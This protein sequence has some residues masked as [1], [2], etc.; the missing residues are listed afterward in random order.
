MLVTPTK[1]RIGPNST[2]HYF[3][4]FVPRFRAAFLLTILALFAPVM[5]AQ[6]NNQGPIA[7][8]PKFEVRRI[9][10]EPHPGPP[11]IPQSEIIQKVAANEDA[12]QK[13]YSTYEFTQSIRVEELENGGGKFSVA[14]YSYLK[15]DGQRYWRA[16]TP[17]TT[18]LRTVKYDLPDVQTM[19]SGPLFFLTSDQAGNYNFLYAGQ[20]KLDEINAYMFQVK[21][22]QL[23]RNRKLFQGLIYV[24]DHDLAIVESYGKFVDELSGDAEGSKFPF[25]MFETY[26]ENFQ[27]RYWLPT[28]I[29]SDDYIAVPNEDELHVRLVVRCSEFKPNAASTSP[30]PP[31]QPSLQ[32]QK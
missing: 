32:S 31:E 30:A 16:T 2:R 19:I 17:V 25:S 6:D 8:P 13:V 22:K 27:G 15:P 14:G 23:L 24:D 3:R 26:R 20:Q 18:T 21:P 29:S 4:G 28:Y 9:P 5:F 11:P 7:P 10:T 12:A 1:Q